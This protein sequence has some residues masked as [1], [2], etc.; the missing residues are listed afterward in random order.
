MEIGRGSFIGSLLDR[1]EDWMDIFASRSFEAGK[2]HTQ[3]TVGM[4][5]LLVEDSVAGVGHHNFCVSLLKILTQS[6]NW[7]VL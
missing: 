5:A 7:E 3:C 1:D 2:P 4:L 6:D